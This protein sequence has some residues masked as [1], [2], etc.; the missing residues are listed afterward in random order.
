MVVV[1][2]FSETDELRRALH[3]S[4]WF[5]TVPPPMAADNQESGTAYPVICWCGARRVDLS[6]DVIGCYHEEEW[7]DVGDEWDGQA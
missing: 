5:G 7:P 6:N 2:V 4:F 1:H 3:L